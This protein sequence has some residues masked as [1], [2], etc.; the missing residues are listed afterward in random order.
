MRKGG[1]TR[2]YRSRHCSP[3]G[4]L[5]LSCEAAIS[6]SLVVYAPCRAS[7]QRGLGDSQRRTHLPTCIRKCPKVLGGPW[8]GILC[9]LDLPTWITHTALAVNNHPL[10]SLYNPLHGPRVGTHALQRLYISA[11]LYSPLQPST[12]L[13]LYILYSIHPSTSPLSSW[14]PPSTI[15]LQPSWEHEDC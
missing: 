4:A 5:L 11:A 14:H 15:Q 13:H 12:S 9:H 10:Y 1:E 3:E 6:H 7:A 2:G 8:V